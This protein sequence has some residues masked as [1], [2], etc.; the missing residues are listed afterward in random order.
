MLA[1]STPVT[2]LSPIWTSSWNS[3]TTTLLI[4]PGPAAAQA[5]AARRNGADGRLP[6]APRGDSRPRGLRP[7]RHLRRPRGAGGCA[8]P[9]GTRR[10]ARRAR[11]ALLGHIHA[12]QEAAAAAEDAEQP[13]RR[14]DADEMRALRSSPLAAAPPK[15]MPRVAGFVSDAESDVT[16]LRGKRSVHAIPHP[17]RAPMAMQN[18]GRRLPWPRYVSARRASP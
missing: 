7:H 8:R 10:R 1:P 12:V 9:R 4:C 15:P 3:A 13:P 6:A 16:L 14:Y 17:Q 2:H 18:A 5:A 11:R